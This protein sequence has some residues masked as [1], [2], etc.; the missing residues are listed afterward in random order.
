MEIRIIIKYS[1]ENV[2]DKQL[3]KNIK[4]EYHKRV[5]KE[6]NEK[7]EQIYSD[8][9]K[10]EKNKISI[11]CKRTK[12]IDLNNCWK[13][14]RSNFKRCIVSSLFYVY[15]FYREPINIESIIISDDVKDEIAIPFNPE[16]KERLDEEFAINENI[17]YLFKMISH[18]EVSDVLYRVLH[19]QVL[20]TKN[21]DFY[22]AYRSFNSMYKFV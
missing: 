16:F 10:F 17:E 7:K 21:K 15:N 19:S 2:N 11:K 4:F 13:T 20:F 14:K 5:Y 12:S 18:K 22:N 1:V 6:H 8:D 3:N 9:V